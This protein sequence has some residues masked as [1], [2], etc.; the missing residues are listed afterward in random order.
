MTMRRGPEFEDL[1]GPEVGGAERDRLLRTHELILQAGPPPELSPRLEAGPTLAMTL[2]R[3]GTSKPR[4]QR[5]ALLAAAI[6]V[7]VLVF[8]GGYAAGNGTKN[9]TVTPVATLKLQGTKEA[10][11]AQAS[12]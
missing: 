4:R 7:L 2:G 8:V 10:P 1:V 9:P 11:R 6:V 5:W 3:A 12:L